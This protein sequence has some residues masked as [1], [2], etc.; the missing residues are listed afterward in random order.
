[1]FNGN[2]DSAAD[3]RLALHIGDGRHY[4]LATK[5]RFDLITLEPPPPSARGVVNLYSTDFYELARK[6]LAPDGILAQWWP[7][8][9]QNVE[10][11]QAMMQSILDVF[12]YVTVWTTDIYEMMVLGSMQPME[13]DAEQIKARFAF[14]GV[15]KALAEVGIANPSELLATYVMGRDGLENFAGAAE[16]VTDNRPRIEYAPWVRPDE[17]RR[18]LPRLLNL[19]GAIPL[20]NATQ[21]FRDAILAEQQE[22]FDFYRLTLAA[23]AGDR[24]L[25]NKLISRVITR[26]PD[27]P[28]YRWFLGDRV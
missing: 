4:L 19:A 21:G 28:Y 8:A 14:P 22:L 10:D 7:I 26:D 5:Q 18:I 24:E 2:L 12:P 20:Q 27:N 3:S 1:L 23:A 6:R 13:M 25:W 17:I 15:R 11:S 9:T 16:S